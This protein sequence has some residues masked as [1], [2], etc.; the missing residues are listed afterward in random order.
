MNT[1][2]PL[3]ICLILISS[4]I[5]LPQAI[6]ANLSQSEDFF[7]FKF[8]NAALSDDY[9]KKIFKSTS[10]THDPQYEVSGDKIRILALVKP[11]VESSS[12]LK[13]AS[14]LALDLFTGLAAGAP[15]GTQFASGVKGNAKVKHHIKSLDLQNQEG[16]LICKPLQQKQ[17]FVN[18]NFID[19]YGM[20]KFYH[21]REIN[22]PYAVMAFD[23]AEN[24][25]EHPSLQMLIK[26]EEKPNESNIYEI[27]NKI[28]QQLK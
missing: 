19:F 21:A 14:A 24:C 27:K 13:F 8:V 15:A 26:T 22:E 18:D 9:E 11:E 5:Q 4:S 2:R 10:K 28:L 16:K 6:A 7:T 23:F 20:A 1:C 17:F 25:F 3:L 12:H